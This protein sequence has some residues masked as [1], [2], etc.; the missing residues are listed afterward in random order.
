MPDPANLH[1][2]A[3]LGNPGREYE[4]T[5]HNAGFLLVERLAESW[6]ANWN[7]EKKFKAEV[8]K[9]NDRRTLLAKPQTFMNLSGEA[10][11]ALQKFYRVP[12]VNV[13]VVVDD[14]D[15]PLGKIRL[16]PDGSP[17]G[18]HGLESVEKHLGT[19]AWPRLRLGIGRRDASQREISGH[20]LGKFG[21][22]EW[23]DFEQVLKHAAQAAECWLQDGALEAMNRFNGPIAGQQKDK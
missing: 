4:R 16:R 21:A 13:L 19:R 7:A 15:L 12:P 17:G 9:A 1:L 11:G 3:G 18:H 20:V 10:V 6:S 8:A 23:T 22:D 2:I 14:A 5:R